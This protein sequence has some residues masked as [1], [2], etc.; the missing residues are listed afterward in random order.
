MNKKLTSKALECIVLRLLFLKFNVLRSS[1]A[2]KISSGR[3]TNELSESIKVCKDFW[4]P[5][6]SSGVRSDMKFPEKI[7]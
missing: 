3:E 1:I 7:N 6:K 5:S 4:Y 2:L